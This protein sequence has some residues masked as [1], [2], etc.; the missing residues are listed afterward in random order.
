VS[1]GASIK[2]KLKVV[3]ACGNGTAGAFAPDVLA[4]A[5]REVI[6]MDCELDHTFPKYNPNPED[7]KMLHALSDRVKETGADLGLA[8]DGD[9]D[10]CGVVDNTGEE[11][12]R[13]QGGADAGARPVRGSSGRQVRGRCE[14]H[15]ALRHRPGAEGERGDDR[16]LEDRP[17]LHQAPRQRAGR[18]GGL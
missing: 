11:I 17:L 7:M 4:R 3:A 18:A 15:R 14:V 5:G 9:G 8:F 16:V 12:F 2:R 6:E 10:R 13:R 1:K